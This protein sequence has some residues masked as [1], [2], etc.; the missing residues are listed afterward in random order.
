MKLNG[1]VGKGTGK[2]GA[3]VFA[4]SGGEQ[5]VR[6]YNPQ[7]SNPQTAAQVEQRAKL[8]LMSQLAADLASSLA[9]RKKGLVSAR[10]QFVSANIGKCT[11][12][13]AGEEKGARID[14][15]L[16][17]IT[18]AS[19]AFPELTDIT[20][21]DNKLK[22]AL[23]TAAPADVKRVVYAAYWWNPLHQLVKLDEQIVSVAGDGRTFPVEFDDNSKAVVVY[24]YGIKD[25]TSKATTKFDEYEIQDQSDIAAVDVLMSLSVA[26]YALTQT[27]SKSLL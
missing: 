18:G 22:V 1:F 7:V 15:N 6:Q 5:I 21:E 17:D 9:F 16:L 12:E 24:A 8:K 19:G 4:I 26:D 20:I 2:L 11:Y 10:N 23:A 13:S 3:S 14:V 27:V 25:T